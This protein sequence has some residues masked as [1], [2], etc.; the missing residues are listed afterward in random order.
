MVS[1]QVH[2]EQNGNTNTDSLLTVP[3]YGILLKLQLMRRREDA[4]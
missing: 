1:T 2:S 4:N 3:S